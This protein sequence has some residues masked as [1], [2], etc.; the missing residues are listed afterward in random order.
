MVKGCL[1][2]IR[3]KL[4]NEQ[5]SMLLM[6]YFVIVLI[7]G[8]GSAFLLAST[9]ELQIAER[10]RLSTVAFYIAEAGIE[11][12][13]YDL[14][15][16]FVNDTS[17]PS[18]ADGTINVYNIGPDTVSF[19]DIPYSDTSLNGGSY[20]ASLKNAPG[21]KDIWVKSVGT[22]KDVSHTLQVYVRM[23]D[24]SPWAYAIFA[25]SGASG[26]MING[27]VDIRGS[28]LALGNNLNPG[29][30]AMD[31][32][33]TAQLVGNNYN[34]LAAS[35]KALVPALPTTIFNG[36]TVDTLNGV[37]RVKKGVVG[38]SGT[39]TVGEPDVSGNGVKETIDGAYVTEGYS[40]NQGTDNVYSDNGKTTAF[41]LGDA[42]HF[43]SLSDPASQDSSKTFQQYFKDNALVLTNQLSTIDPNSSFSYS[44]EYGSISM[45]AG[46]LTISGRVYVDENNSVTFAKAESNK[47]INYTGSGSLLVTGNVGVNTNLLTVGNSSF[48]TNIMGIMTPNTMTFNEANIDVMGL[49]YAENTITVMK[50]TDMMGTVVSNY[51]DMGTN[52]PAIFQVPD[53]V[54]NLPPGLIGESSTWFMVVVWQKV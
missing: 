36:E 47:T 16:D 9:V 25:G 39:A 35:L 2:N 37:L 38:L 43:P 10:Q 45:N 6:A 52:V 49:F 48:P 8:L 41:D 11:R 22:I 7:L 28:V 13:L 21:G 1:R 29:D 12:A 19:Y 30:L 3:A 40:G 27:N 4:R 26:M 51:F 24:I 5:G 15:Q 17:L 34:G 31:L 54:N 53:T 33:G 20:T 42:V 46:T 23:V 44:N 50:Q 18:W 14:R 32:G